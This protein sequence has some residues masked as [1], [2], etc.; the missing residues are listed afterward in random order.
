MCYIEDEYDRYLESLEPSNECPQ[1]GKETSR[2]GYCSTDCF[3]AS[4]L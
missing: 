2:D 1:C 4:M 3:N